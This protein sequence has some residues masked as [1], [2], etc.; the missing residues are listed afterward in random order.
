[1][2]ARP[3]SFYANG[4]A[5]TAYLPAALASLPLAASQRMS[6]PNIKI[7]LENKDLWNKFSD[8]TCEMIITRAGR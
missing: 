1:M 7:T 6:D 5:M 8:N 2:A 3:E 4:A